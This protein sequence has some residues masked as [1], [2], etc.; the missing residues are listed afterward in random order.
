MPEPAVHLSPDLLDACRRGT[1]LT[2]T[3]R[4]RRELV[5]AYDARMLAEGRRAW[6]S[7]DAFS[8][9]GWLTHRHR[10]ARLDRP[11]LPRLLS[12]TEELLLWQTAAPDGL[13]ALAPLARDAWTLA[14]QWRVPLD[15]ATLGR[16]E[17][18]RLFRR[19]LERFREALRD[20]RAITPAELPD[21]LRRVATSSRAAS[22]IPGQLCCFGF[23]ATP[24][25]V[26]DYLESLRQAG[27][28][29]IELED[30]GVREPRIR[31]IELPDPR[32]ELNAAAQWCRQVLLAD[33]E[34]RIGVV[35]PD[36]ARRRDAVER[37]FAAWLEPLG[38]HAE[39]RP[40]DLGGGR[41]LAEQPVWRDAMRWLRLCF[42]RL[43]AA[44]VRRL[45]ASPYL[46]LPP[47]PR[48]PAELPDA[49]DL[50]E[51][52]AATGAEW[53][54]LRGHAASSRQSFGAWIECFR[55]ALER[56][57]WTGREAG[58]VQYQA[59]REAI[60]LLDEA[61]GAAV[62]SPPC[63]AAAA[64]AR[65]EHLAGQR[66]FAA[67]RAPAP[68]QILGLLETTGLRFTHLWVTGLAEES[69]PGP[70]Q[71]NPLL[72]LSVQR[73]HGIP[74][75]DPDG[76]LDFARRRL[77]HWQAAADEVVLSHALEEDGVE[78]GPSPLT[79]HRPAEPVAWVVTDYQ[80]ATHP[81]FVPAHVVL[82]GDSCERAA[83][84][85]AD[86]VTGGAGLLR[87][88]ALCPFRRWA[89]HT[90]RL[91]PPPEPHAF[92]DARDRGLL[93]HEVLHR[94]LLDPD[95]R[96]VRSGRPD[97]ARLDE[98]VGERVAERYRR[99]PAAVCEIER[100]RLR[101]L[102]ER[103][104]A[105]EAARAP[106]AVRALEQEVSVAV[107][108]IRLR[109]RLDRVDQVDGALAVLDYKTGAV[110]PQRLLDERLTEPQ[111]P[112]YAMADEA[113]RA[114]LFVELADD[115]VLRGAASLDLEL[116]PARLTP[117]PEAW[118]A[119]RARWRERLEVLAAEILA[120]RA[121]VAPV[122]PEACRSCDLQPFC[123]IHEQALPWQE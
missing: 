81:A 29:L 104:S 96:P 6:P 40:F 118:D 12:A 37:Q 74:R 87:D 123:R 10:Q 1:V 83:P 82:D 100:R 86:Q 112:L 28:R 61:R 67:E 70:V 72:P 55:R 45:F 78:R 25:A 89:R 108:G 105:L 49:F 76:E 22:S 88:Q 27:T 13:E 84:P 79:A 18:G 63:D 73:A 36:L 117:L 8:V 85:A 33:P 11:D 20:L 5:R 43:P 77:A 80:S 91:G 56:A 35:V 41:P 17:D 39:R 98:I 69:W 3:E 34:A 16:T 107:G 51:L 42:D 113:I 116:S 46:D 38:A 120:G 54:R 31:R 14:W 44:E 95:G 65:L 26:A 21:L 50:A 59:R 68:V 48:L 101:T 111:L 47:A 60:E 92:P 7:V 75:V 52:A 94:A 32:A 58:S 97:P 30:P 2:P 23:E 106:F 19:W 102:L 99:F 110:R 15:A 53:L 90:L 93:V 66:P 62:R 71:A 115:V 9:T 121:D 64:I 4:L 119:L 103:W 109:L 122:G 24:A 114:V 57:R